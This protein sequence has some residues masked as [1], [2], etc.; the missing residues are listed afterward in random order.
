LKQLSFT[1]LGG[2][3]MRK[4]TE[5]ELAQYDGRN[6]NPVYIGYKGKVYDVSNSFLWKGGRH[7]V[8]HSAGMDL[9][10]ALKQAPH[11]EEILK[12]FPIVGLLNDV[13]TSNKSS[14]PL[15]L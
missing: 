10:D 5:E 2:S 15:N 3:Y 13:D 8:F 1:V 6:G 7:Q 12:K 14:K 11:G 9:T 4:F